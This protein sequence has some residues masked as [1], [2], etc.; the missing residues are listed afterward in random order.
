MHRILYNK[1]LYFYYQLHVIC[2]N[3][4]EL[5]N[6]S[7]CIK[8]KQAGNASCNN[9]D[10]FTGEMSV[11]IISPLTLCVTPQFSSVMAQH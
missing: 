9:L 7:V 8:C 2:L 4:Y 11:H 3:V 10:I 5:S 6:F 1:Q